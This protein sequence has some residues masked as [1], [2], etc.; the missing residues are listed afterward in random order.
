MPSRPRGKGL[1]ATVIAC[2]LLVFPPLMRTQPIS[3]VR[4][5][6]RFS[7]ADDSFTF[8]GVYYFDNPGLTPAERSIYY[9]YVHI[10]HFWKRESRKSLIMALVFAISGM[11]YF[12]KWG[13]KLY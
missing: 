2:T 5:S 10:T 12:H 11:K 3:F 1:L 4:E 13:W 7:L 8:S 6:L 9:P